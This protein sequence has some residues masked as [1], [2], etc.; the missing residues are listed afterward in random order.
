M[1]IVPNGYER[2]R[3]GA[4]NFPGDWPDHCGGG[5][6]GGGWWRVEGEKLCKLVLKG[7][8]I[9]KDGRLGDQDCAHVSSE[10]LYILADE[11]VV[12][13]GLIPVGLEMSSEV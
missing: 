13:L 2:T 10:G 11:D 6:S 1:D 3:E 9:V 8:L 7:L 5:G 12:L 4:G